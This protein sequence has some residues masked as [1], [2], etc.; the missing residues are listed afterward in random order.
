[1]KPFDAGGWGGGSGMGEDLRTCADVE[2]DPG[3]GGVEVGPTE[4]R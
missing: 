1:M 2:K 3:G 4:A